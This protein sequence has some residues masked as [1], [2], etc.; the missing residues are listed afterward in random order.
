MS[1]LKAKQYDSMIPC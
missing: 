1:K